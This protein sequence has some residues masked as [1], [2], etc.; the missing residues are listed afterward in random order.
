[1]QEA[2][3]HH[4]TYQAAQLQQ[5]FLQNGAGTVGSNTGQ[6]QS[7][8]KHSRPAFRLVPIPETVNGIGGKHPRQARPD[9]VDTLR[10][11]RRRHILFLSSSYQR[12]SATQ[13]ENAQVKPSPG[14]R[15]S[16]CRNKDGKR[17]DHTHITPNQ[18]RIARTYCRIPSCL[19]YH[20]VDELK[21]LLLRNLLFF[22][23]SFSLRLLI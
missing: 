23:F 6:Q 10:G 7:Q 17:H 15:T 21:A 16:I 22:H 9:A 2:H 8:Q 13:N 12:G 1:M 20:L 11:V 19:L 3:S 4:D 5:L 18:E 14:S